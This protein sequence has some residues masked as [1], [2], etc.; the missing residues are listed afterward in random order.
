MKRYIIIT[1]YLLSTLV[2][3]S[4]SPVA[5]HTIAVVEDPP[6]IAIEYIEPVEEE[7][8]V[9]EFGVVDISNFSLA[10]NDEY[11]IKYNADIWNVVPAQDFEFIDTNVI[12]END[13]VKIIG[14]NITYLSNTTPDDYFK[15]LELA[16]PNMPLTGVE[17]LSNDTFNV[18]GLDIALIET[19]A[20]FT[21]TDIENLIYNQIITHENVNELGGL[22]F[23]D[24]RPLL[25]QFVLIICDD[26]KA[27]TF[28]SSFK[29]NSNSNFYN[30]YYRNITLDALDGIIQS[31]SSIVKVY[32]K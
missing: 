10:S 22:N 8:A 15:L 21:K 28:V 23:L 26:N 24:Y 32:D 5:S 6:E 4:C 12:L 27:Y 29:N 14:S 18:N 20:G 25:S 17:I 19:S 30:N 13:V 3:A 31:I 1:T 16:I 9:V 2:L 11:S 7:L